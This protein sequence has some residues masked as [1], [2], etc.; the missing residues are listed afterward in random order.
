MS[1]LTA[2]S[3]ALFTVITG[4]DMLRTAT[5]CLSIDGP[6]PEL[7]S[8]KYSSPP[9]ENIMADNLR[10]YITRKIGPLK[11]RSSSINLRTATDCLSKSN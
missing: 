5:E 8:M 9:I 4:H 3:P 10:C 7:L 11:S 6:R 1:T 2:S